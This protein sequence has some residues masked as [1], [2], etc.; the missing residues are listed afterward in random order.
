MMHDDEC[1]ARIKKAKE[2]LGDELLLLVHHY[3]RDEIYCHADHTGDSLKLSRYACDSKARYIVFCGVHFMA[4]VA[5]ILTR[6]DQ[7]S[8]LPDLSAGCQLA[9]TA[10]PAIVQG[11]WRDI[12]RAL[13]REASEVITPIT[14]INSAACLKAFCG[15]R[16]GAVCTSSNAR[17]VMDWA[18]EK[19]EKIFFFPDQHLGRNTAYAMGLSLDDIVVWDFTQ[20]RG[21]LSPQQIRD[22]K[23]ILWGG[24]CSVHQMFRTE[25]LTA[26]R[27]KYPSMKLI[28]H[29]ECSFDVC[30][31]ADVI[32]STETILKT[33]RESKSGDHWAIGTELN[34]VNRLGEEVKDRG[35][36]VK[37]LSPTLC[38]CSTMYR[39]DQQHLAW[40]LESLVAGHV[41]NRIQVPEDIAQ[42]AHQALDRM[43]E[44]I[45]ANLRQKQTTR[46][47][48][49]PI[50]DEI[51]SI[52]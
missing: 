34:L 25:H 4:E 38:M 45:P 22:A 3:Q 10:D 46:P 7:I 16:G 52:A 35:I 31:A 1:Y 43:L 14:Y 6:P 11:A 41:V 49:A 32:G 51:R 33:V 50:M 15:E 28:A 23:L 30:Q 13:G 2:T 36:V 48:K 39:I 18:W 40:V 19:R 24:F 42:S 29:P 21:G 5:D 27:E 17:A 47:V 26:L 8:I 20:P 37:F 44:L 9:D 12:S